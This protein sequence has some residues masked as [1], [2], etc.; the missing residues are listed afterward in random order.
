MNIQAFNFSVNVLRVLLWQYN[1][2]EN[3][4]GLLQ[5]KQRWYDV[6]HTQFW[7]DWIRD[8]FDLRTANDF[9][10]SVWSRILD[11]PINIE[12]VESPGSYPAF[13]F[14]N[15]VGID[16]TNS[17]IRNFMHGNFATP[18]NALE[19]LS[20]EQKRLVLRLRYY[21]ITSNVTVSSINR[22]LA[23][24]FPD[25]YAYV[26]DNNDMTISYI[27]SQTPDARTLFLM[28]DADI[29]PRPSGVSYDVR[30]VPLV[31]WGF[32]EDRQNFDRGN[33][34]TLV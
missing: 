33:F 12:S 4:Q 15:V 3:L 30:I 21:E 11:V 23:D 32:D 29:L 24:V 9:G 14:S 28:E 34:F 6:N 7:R 19:N 5:R 16:P 18:P 26:L 13:G 20:T 25:N 2:A 22:I 8:V 10:L 17:P 27:F 31:T 1:E